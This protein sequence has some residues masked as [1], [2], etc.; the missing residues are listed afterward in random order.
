MSMGR[1]PRTR[2][3]DTLAGR[4]R[5]ERARRRA[6]FLSEGREA[7]VVNLRNLEK[8]CLIV[9]AMVF[10]LA[11]AALVIFPGWV[12]S[13]AH[14][15]FF[16]T[17]LLLALVMRRLGADVRRDE[18]RSM[19]LCLVVE[20]VLVGFA[21]VLDTFFSRSLPG[22]FV[23]PACVAF[24]VVIVAP[25]GLPMWVAAVAEVVFVALSVLTKPALV[26]QFD[27]FSAVTGLIVALATSQLVMSLRLSDFQVR[28]EYRELS[29]RDG[30][31]GIYNK[32]ALVSMAH[33]RLATT[34]PR[35]SGAMFLFDI[36]R[37]KRVNDRFGHHAGDEVL[38]GMGLALQRT[39]RSSDVVGRFGGDE[40]MV[41]ASGL[42]DVGV[43]RAKV[44]EVARL[45][46]EAGVNATGEEVSLSAGV[47]WVEDGEAT[48]ESALRQADEALYAAKRAGR[49][50]GAAVRYVSESGTSGVGGVAASG[51]PGVGG[52]AASGVD[53]PGASP[54]G[55]S[56]APAA[57][58]DPAAPKITIWK[59][60]A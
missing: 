52:V 53:A 37:F 12:P 43:M 25:Y 44:N 16:G 41:L 26:A 59:V 56:G 34:N 29:L 6:Y 47:V 28:E 7:S 60:G 36:D 20:A 57:T 3:T 9:P 45:L 2:S 49:G 54:S 24:P 14:F 58:P 15:A 35:A 21:V 46:R 42:V 23:Q 39:F 13:P 10:F 17:S 48:Y 31:C 18:V 50:R 8:I 22:V 27:A 33:A 19:A 55:G 30:L 51:V 4:L 40:F 32:G 11:V 5:N 38:R 1:R